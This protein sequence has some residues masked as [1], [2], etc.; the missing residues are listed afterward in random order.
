MCGIIKISNISKKNKSQCAERK[1]IYIY[2]KMFY[3]H[4]STAG[5]TWILI[6]PQLKG[7]S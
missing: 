2:V 7:K 4:E 3:M 1:I 6:G 5:Q